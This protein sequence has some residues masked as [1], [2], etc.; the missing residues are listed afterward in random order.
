MIASLQNDREQTVPRCR[1]T[2]GEK[3]KRKQAGSVGSAKRR[4]GSISASP[5]AE[6]AILTVP[7]VLASAVNSALRVSRP[8][9]YRYLL[10]AT[11][12]STSAMAQA[13]G[14][15]ASISLSDLD[16]SNGF[17]INGINEFDLSGDS[18]SSVGDINGDGVDDVI[19]GASSVNL[20]G[21]NSVGASY[22]VFGGRGVGNSGSLS[23]S[24][25]NG[26]NGFKINGS[27]SYGGL[28]EST[29][30]AGDINGDGVDDVIISVPGADPNGVNNA[31]ASYVVFGGAGVGGN[32]VLDVSALDGVIGFAVNGINEGAGRDLSVSSA[33]D[34]NGDGV[35][36]VIIGAEYAD[37][38]NARSAGASYVVFGGGSVGSGGSLDLSGLDGSNGFVIF[39]TD[40]FDGLGTSVSGAGDV[41][42]DGIERCDQLRA[43]G[44]DLNGVSVRGCKLCCIRWWGYRQRRFVISGRSGWL[45][46]VCDQRD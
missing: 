19:I 10:A 31:G 26:V 43:P 11:L 42:G 9:P 46:R 30:D 16:G 45:Q 13:Q 20:N 8:Q 1:T 18:V 32:G 17:V 5:T 36:D 40:A 44:A 12:M 22:V 15:S 41:N 27:D 4:A 24:D 28:G 21:V 29:S 39:G 25:L 33:G 23:L 14:F 3:I 2:T 7:T 37:L 35:D 6:Y 38:N 34:I